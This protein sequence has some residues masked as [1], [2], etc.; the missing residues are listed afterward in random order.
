MSNQKT[1][2]FQAANDLERQGWLDA[3]TDAI[4]F[5]LADGVKAPVPPTKRET[6]VEE[7]MPR[8][9]ENAANKVCADCKALDPSWGVVNLG[10]MVC[11]ECSGVHRSM[12][13]LVSKV[14]SL[15][16]DRSIWTESL[17]RL[18]VEIGNDRSN[19]F[20][21]KHCQQERLQA[22]VERD[23]RESFIRAKYQV[24]SWIPQLPGED[25]GSLS[26]QLFACV[27][28]NNLMRTIQ[29]LAHGADVAFEDPDQ[30]DPKMKT[31]LAVAKHHNQTLQVELLEQNRALSSPKPNE[32]T[33][34]ISKKGHLYKTG[35]DRTGWKRRW[36]TV[37]QFRGL[38][39]FRSETDPEIQGDIKICEMLS[40]SCCDDE[41]SR[42]PKYSHCF[43]VNTES[44][45]YLFCADSK[46]EME[47]WIETL[48][49][50][51]RPD[52]AELNGFDKV[53]YLRKKDPHNVG[54]WRRRWFTLKGK[55]LVY[56]RR[57]S[58]RGEEGC[59]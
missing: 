53:G 35:N 32:P 16:L 6:S 25:R 58:G 3:I 37:D 15:E 56:Y 1:Y 40:I 46:P 23:I 31:C 2:T 5:G 47:D 59:S 14:R 12:G 20:W 19:Q 17:I 45:G 39:Y 24:R 22:G 42:D 36:C 41:S 10:I 43:E 30:S 11:I 26:R 4:L 44:R 29:L 18:M 57:V 7:I 54:G 48:R 50:V 9:Q 33:Q 21:E 28:S 55:R 52:G 51:I 27:A 38:E 49:K 34:L 13:V 8:L